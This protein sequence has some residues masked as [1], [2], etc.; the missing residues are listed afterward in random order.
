MDFRLALPAILT[1]LFFTWKLYRL[2]RNIRLAKKTGLPYAVS[3]IHELETLAF[4][5][6]VLFRWYCHEHLLRGQGWPDW[7]RFMV[8]NWHYEDKGRAHREYGSVFLVVSAGGIICYSTDADVSMVMVTKRKTIVKM[9]E[10]MSEYGRPGLV[11]ILVSSQKD[12]YDRAIW[13]ECSDY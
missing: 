13:S 8:K 6:D 1:A 4:F 5:T 10:Q 12:R 7:A 11:D 2:A 9:R 3:P